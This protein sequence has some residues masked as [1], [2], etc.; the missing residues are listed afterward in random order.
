MGVLV[1]TL[2]DVLVKNGRITAFAF[3]GSVVWLSYLVSN[4]LTAGRIH[5]SAIAILVG[6][7]LA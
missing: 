3:V 5:G 7:V 6:L 2:S 1:E 4:R